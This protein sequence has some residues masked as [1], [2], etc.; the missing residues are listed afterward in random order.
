MKPG[1]N[2]G[3]LIKWNDDRGF[4]FIKSST[5][6]KEVFLHISAVKTKG[7]RPKVG[8]MIVYELITGL[9]KKTRA[10]GASIQDVPSQSSKRQKVKT[11]LAQQKNEKR[12]LLGTI[13]GIGGL[14]A[15]V[16]VQ[17]QFSPSRS[18]TLM[19][20]ITK[21][22]CVVKGNISIATGNKLYHV[23]GMEDY[24]GTIIDSGKGERW[25]C[26]ESEAISAGWRKAPR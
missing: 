25:F 6:G 3:Q 1:L 18:P 9:D 2:K 11:S 16:I 4:G 8:D 19:T 24:D 21:P 15:F 23:P 7:R 20:L 12:G 22:G 26:S 5:G 13:F 14:V 17:M 10:S